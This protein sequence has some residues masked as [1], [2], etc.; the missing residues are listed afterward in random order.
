MSEIRCPRCGKVVGEDHDQYIQLGKD[1]NIIYKPFCLRAIILTCP[2]KL[3]RRQFDLSEVV[4]KR[5][6]YHKDK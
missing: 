6:L 4:I 2:D 1:K 5:Q 3:C